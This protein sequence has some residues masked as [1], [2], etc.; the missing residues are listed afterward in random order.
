M[1]H[2]PLLPCWCPQVKLAEGQRSHAAALQQQAAAHAAALS[3]V[4]AS[5]TA[6]M[7]KVQTGVEH[8]ARGC[9]LQRL[10]TRQSHIGATLMPPA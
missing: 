9:L 2:A 4:E 6:T 1:A 3:S 8:A 7:S 10:T 5:H